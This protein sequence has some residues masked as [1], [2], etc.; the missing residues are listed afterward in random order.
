MY[1]LL[2]LKW[3]TNKDLQETLLTVMWQPGWEGSLGENSSN[4]RESACQ[5]RETQVPSL[6]WE[7]P[8]CC[9]AAKPV[10]HNY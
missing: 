2:Y 8:A 7:D 6:V 10:S 4:G 1:T 5:C 3:I 9:E